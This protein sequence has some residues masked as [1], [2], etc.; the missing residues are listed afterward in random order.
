MGAILLLSLMLSG[1]AGAVNPTLPSTSLVPYEGQD[2]G[3]QA[4][5]E[6]SPL[7]PG[8]ANL[9]VQFNRNPNLVDSDTTCYK[10]R[11]YVFELNDDRAPKFL[12]ETTCG[13]S[14]P[15]S[16]AVDEQLVPKLL[17]AVR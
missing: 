2:Q 10:I 16:K 4:S 13:P 11:A 8:S 7:L 14:K 15:R 17:P 9:T 6:T 12:R 3:A 1:P 5:A